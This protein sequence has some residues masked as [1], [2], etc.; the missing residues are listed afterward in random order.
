MTNKNAFRED[1]SRIH[2][3]GQKRNKKIIRKLQIP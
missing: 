2:P 3:V 1:D